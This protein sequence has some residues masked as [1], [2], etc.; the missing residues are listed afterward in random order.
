M[1]SQ[2]RFPGDDGT[3]STRIGRGDRGIEHVDR[4][5]SEWRWPLVI[6]WGLGLAGYLAARA[7]HVPISVPELGIG[8][9]TLTVG[10]ALVLAFRVVR[11]VKGWSGVERQVGAVKVGQEAL[12][13]ALDDRL[14]AMDTRVG[15]TGQA[16][17]TLSARLDMVIGHLLGAEALAELHA[18]EAR[19]TRGRRREDT[20]VTDAAPDAVDHPAPTPRDS[21]H[22]TPRFPRT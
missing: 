4:A 15:S 9:G 16:V 20:G 19:Q 11:L 18:A 13:T 5:W 21:N 6:A 12:S 1:T 3:R 2:P 7:L 22:R 14:R 10:T 17:L 8:G